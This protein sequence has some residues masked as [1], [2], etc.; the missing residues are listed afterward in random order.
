LANG[1]ADAIL[2]NLKVPD[3]RRLRIIDEA[4]ANFVGTS[5]GRS[6]QG[7]ICCE[8]RGAG[9]EQLPESF[10]NRSSFL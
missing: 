10:D 5:I 3:C 8:L 6:W 1:F 7:L 9:Q 2:I 4:N